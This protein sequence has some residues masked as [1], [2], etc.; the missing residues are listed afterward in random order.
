MT[1]ARPLLGLLGLL[2]VPAARGAMAQGAPPPRAD[3]ARADSARRPAQP[4]GLPAGFGTLRQDDVAV[5]VQYL[6]LTV[7]AIPLSEDV[8]RTLSPDSY[9]TLRELR[10]SKAKPLEIIR[11]RLG[12]PSVQAWY[13]SFFN[14]E[15]GEARYNAFDFVVRSAGR[16]FRP[17]DVLPLTPGFGEGRLRQ[18]GVQSAIY[19]FD[20]AVDVNQPLAVSIETQQSDAWTDVLQR[21]ERERALIWSRAGAAGR[22]KP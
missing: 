2:A 4:D 21:L 19:A 14:L 7:R 9:R 15:Q 1:L 12:L 10:E 8:I 17:L 20:P 16:D 11:A 3:S 5:R 22:Q 6:G 13:V 18:R